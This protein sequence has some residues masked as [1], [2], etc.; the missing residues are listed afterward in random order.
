MDISFT[1]SNGHIDELIDNLLE[2]VGVHHPYIIREMILSALKAG[3]TSDYLADLKLMRT[4]MK[5]M[6]YTNKV[7]SPYRSRRKVT[8]FGSARTL[9]SEPIYQKCVR[10]SQL[11]AQNNYMVITGGGGGIMQAGNEGAGK[12]N[13]F[14][15]NIELPFEQDTNRVMKQSDRVLMYKYFFNRKVAF[16]KEADA[17]AL[18]PG[19]FG[20]LDEAMETLTLVQTGKNPPIPLVLIDDNNGT[21]WEDLFEFM[22]DVLLPKGLISGEDFG[23]FTITRSAEEAMEV[24]DSF[25]KVYHS[26]RYV[27]KLLVIRLNKALTQQQIE[28]LE[29]EFSEIL[30]PDTRIKAVSAF[31]KE[32][33]EPDLWDLPRLAIHF[34]RRSY[35]LLNSFIRRINSF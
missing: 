14:A 20:T 10:F 30:L 22:R 27:G 15:V 7:F 33:D 4:T 19:G 26:S 24:I 35:G 32:R 25:Y 2:E 13:S 9:P 6:R 11:L 8:I 29:S 12:E 18:F 1:R 16:L 23:L 21:Y 5:E 17:V 3:Q 31:D 28:T 34:N